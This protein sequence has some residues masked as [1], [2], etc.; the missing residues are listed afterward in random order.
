MVGSGTIKTLAALVGAMTLATAILIWMETPPACPTVQ[1]PLEVL[2]QGR[3]RPELAI[4]HQ[5]DPGIR[6]QSL[7][8]R[9]VIVHD[10]GRDGSAVTAGCH[11]LIGRGQRFADGEIHATGLW[12]RQQEGRH[13]RVPGHLFNA[14]SIGVCLLADCRQVPP[15]RRQFQ[16]LVDLI[17]ALQVTCEI[18]RDHVYLHRELGEAGCPGRHF[19]AAAFREGLIPSAR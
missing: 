4:I 15:T 12:R 13:V 8:W 9:N 16:A 5:T 17:R 18:P 11:F 14:D 6:V 7:K 1:L 10:H 3:W 19:P 2:R